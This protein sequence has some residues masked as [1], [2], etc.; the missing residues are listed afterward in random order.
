[1]TSAPHHIEVFHIGGTTGWAYAT[2]DADGNQIGE[3]AY[4]WR[5]ADAMLS[6]RR[7]CD[8]LPIWEF[9]TQGRKRREII[10]EAS[11]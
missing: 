4:E 3:A 10:T 1:M 8:G 9:N 7:F 2:F 11:K 6:A 5:K